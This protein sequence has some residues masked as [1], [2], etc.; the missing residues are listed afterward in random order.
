VGWARSSPTLLPATTGLRLVVFD[1]P[2]I[3]VGQIQL[4][5][6]SRSLAPQQQCAVPVPAERNGP[7]AQFRGEN[8]PVQEIYPFVDLSPFGVPRAQKRAP[9]FDLPRKLA[10]TPSESPSDFAAGAVLRVGTV[11]WNI[12]A[13]CLRHERTLYAGSAASNRLIRASRGD[14]NRRAA[15]TGPPAPTAP[16]QRRR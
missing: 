5:G 10:L 4:S 16:T 6:S 15:P 14:P 3:L 8:Y 9:G 1:A 2:Q 7:Q 13:N 11:C 12:R